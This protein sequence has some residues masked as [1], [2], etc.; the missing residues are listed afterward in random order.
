MYNKKMQKQFRIQGS[1][2]FLTYS[3]CKGDKDEL[4]KFLQTKLSIVE[5]IIAK[6]EHKDGGTHFHCYLGLEKRC[7]ITNAGYLDW[8]PVGQ[9]S[10]IYHPQIQVVKNAF[11]VQQYCKKDENFITNMKFNIFQTAKD[12][13][14]TGNWKEALKFI[15]E[16]APQEIKNLD[17]WENN[18]KKVSKIYAQKSQK[19]Q[20]IKED[21]VNCSHIKLIK[22][23]CTVISGKSG[24]GKTQ[25]AKTLFN[26]PLLVRHIDKLK[27]FNEMEHDGIIFDDMNFSHWP[28][29][30]C[31]HLLDIE[32][33]TDIN[34]KCTMIT[35]PAGTKRVFTTN[36]EGI[37]IF[38]S[39]CLA[40]RRRLNCYTLKNSLIPEPS[41]VMA[42]VTKDVCKEC[43][44]G[45]VED[46]GHFF[47]DDEDEGMTE[48]LDEGSWTYI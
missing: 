7:N 29:T 44:S 34:V 47:L 19:S 9:M 20:Y 25:F 37:S 18:F 42:Q 5:Y 46:M 36:Q 11:A 45:C 33:D 26:N 28:R 35:I 13:A 48:V 10:I 4:L 15:V 38:S 41:N 2:L 39:S 6:E 22:N 14:K 43:L 23:R 24:W 27:K 3:Q 8:E 1:K 16:R 31:I 30:S 17:K 40:I 32:E 21:F 12:L